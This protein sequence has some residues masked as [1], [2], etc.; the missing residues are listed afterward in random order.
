M[1]SKKKV[2]PATKKMVAKKVAPKKVAVKKT[3]SKK[4]AVEKTVEEIAQVVVEIEP[5]RFEETLEAEASPLKTQDVQNILLKYLELAKKKKENPNGKLCAHLPKLE[6]EECSKVAGLNHTESVNPEDEKNIQEEPEEHFSSTLSKESLSLTLDKIKLLAEALEQKKEKESLNKER[7][8]AEKLLNDFEEEYA[9][10]MSF[11]CVARRKLRLQL[12]EFETNGN[13]V[14]LKE[15]FKFELNMTH[16]VM[17]L[18]KIKNAFHELFAEAK[19]EQEKFVP[20]ELDP[21]M[22]AFEQYMA[23]YRSLKDR[24]VKYGCVGSVRRSG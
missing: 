19:L 20:Q 23:G 14:A 6:L 17:M 16:K 15:A 13:G 24:M 8:N 10:S 12:D 2:K 3:A 1:A 4:P 11:L 18:D 9:S 22:K 21:A 7:I 5:Q